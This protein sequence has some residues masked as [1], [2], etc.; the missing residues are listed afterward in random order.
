MVKKYL[1]ITVKTQDGENEYHELQWTECS[2]IVFNNKKALANKLRNILE[3][4]RNSDSNKLNRKDNEDCY[5]ELD[6]D[7]TI[8]QIEG[9]AEFNTKEDLITELVTRTRVF[10][11]K[12]TQEE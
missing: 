6:R 3:R 9:C 12:D 7:K 2:E 1:L 5:P 4:Y 10:E 8:M 11:I